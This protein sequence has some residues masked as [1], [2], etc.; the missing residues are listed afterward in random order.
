MYEQLNNLWE[1]TLEECGEVEKIEIQLLLEGIFRRYGFD[2]RDYSFSFIR[3]RVWHRIRIEKLIGI[4][5]LQAKVLHD[6]RLMEK[7]FSD[8]SIHVTEMFRDPGFFQA[9]RNKVVPLLRDLPFIR[10]WH[11]GCSTGEEVYSMAI[12]LHE[13]GLFHKTSIYATDMNENFLKK[14]ETGVFPLERMQEFTK[15]YLAAG[16]TRSF[17]E[18]YTVKH[19]SVVFHA[20][21]RENTV[22]AQH[23]LVTDRS[24][25]E[26]HV[27][28]CRN[29]MIYFSKPLQNHV[30][31]LLYD[32]LGLSGILGL[33]NKE[34]I[35]FTS[36]SHC[37]EEID[38]SERLYSKIK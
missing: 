38:S 9:F 17:S 34:A 10:I 19:E 20:F 5:D 36:R 18:Y 14:A 6:P 7:L 23:N 1:N 3:R 27:I 16:G 12:L 35:A 29:V 28:V 31:A 30:H 8:F 37:Y 21:L 15:N 24:F 11:A 4:S 33:G 25:N 32:S 2:F 13:E 22:F 26:F